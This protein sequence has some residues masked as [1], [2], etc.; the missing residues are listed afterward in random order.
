MPNVLLVPESSASQYFSSFLVEIS[1]IWYILFACG[2]N[3]RLG[4]LFSMLIIPCRESI[5][6][7]E[8]PTQPSV[9][10]AVPCLSSIQWGA[11]TELFKFLQQQTCSSLGCSVN[12]KHVETVSVSV[13][14]GNTQK[15]FWC[16]LMV[17]TYINSHFLC[18]PLGLLG[19]LFK[20]LGEW[21]SVFRCCSTWHIFRMQPY[22]LW[23]QLPQAARRATVPVCPFVYTIFSLS[24]ERKPESGHCLI[25][26]IFCSPHTC[27]CVWHSGN[28]DQ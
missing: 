5:M 19:F 4:Y 28:S 12:T 13:E 2:D 14:K 22:Y 26:P 20:K 25:S 3:F 1:Y 16:L 24:L 27:T 8:A 11:G 10:P 23:S 6:E 18:F 7:L 17:V 21:P 9:Q 15:L